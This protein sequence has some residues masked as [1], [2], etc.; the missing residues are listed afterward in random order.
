V[1]SLNRSQAEATGLG[2]NRFHFGLVSTWPAQ[3]FMPLLKILARDAH[4]TFV[5]TADCG[6]DVRRK[7][8]EVLE[9]VDFTGAMTFRKA[10]RLAET[11]ERE[12][13]SAVIVNGPSTRTYATIAPCF[14]LRGI[15]VAMW[16]QEWLGP[17][18][19]FARRAATPALSLLTR[20]ASIVVAQ[21]SRAAALSES[22]GAHH[23]R[24]RLLRL[25]TEVSGPPQRADGPRGQLLFV[26]RLLRVKGVHVLLDAMDQLVRK[27][28]D[29]SLTIVG[30]G[31]ERARLEA[32][33]NRLGL[34]PRVTFA[35]TVPQDELSRYYSSAKALI[36]PS[37]FDWEGKEQLEIWGYVLFEAAHYGLALVATDAV[38]ASP[39]FFVGEEDGIVV[40]WGNPS[41]LAEALERIWTHD[42]LRLRLGRGARERV[43]GFTYEL[44]AERLLT[45]MLGAARGGS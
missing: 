44:A 22:L 40:P 36:L 14:R 16:T 12:A 10:R 25:G 19:S 37:V 11:A 5:F 45:A 15:P 8:T 31:P 26:G 41:A 30:D 18:V 13:W 1:T 43:K 39:D 7:A 33:A 29:I 23:D 42:D 34:A 4:F 2:P 35:G 6:E 17:H 28:V 27:R 9:N 21:G 24:I 3:N 38:G 32:Q 20:L